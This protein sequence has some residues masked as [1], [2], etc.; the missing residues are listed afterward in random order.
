MSELIINGITFKNADNL[1]LK[2]DEY[3]VIHIEKTF[4]DFVDGEPCDAHI[5][6]CSMHTDDIEYY[7]LREDC[8]GS[9]HWSVENGYRSIHDSGM[10]GDPRD[11]ALL[12]H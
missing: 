4:V 12:I 8:V 1:K 5:E 10:D 3:N 2:L 6:I 9:L 7:I 11:F